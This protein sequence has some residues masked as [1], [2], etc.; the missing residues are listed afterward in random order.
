MKLKVLNEE[1]VEYMQKIKFKFDPDN[2]G[3]R[4]P[5]N[6][7]T[8][9][10]KVQMKLQFSNGHCFN[11]NKFVTQVNRPTFISEE[12]KVIYDK[13]FEYLADLI[14]SGENLN[15][16]SCDTPLIYSQYYIEALVS[17][18]QSCG[19]VVAGIVLPF[20]VNPRNQAPV[21][22]PSFTE[23]WNPTTQSIVS[24]LVDANRSLNTTSM[25]IEPSQ[26]H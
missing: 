3:C 21:L 16:S 10:V 13:D 26:M 25:S 2:T 5:I 23:D 15:I 11:V 8:A 7:V 9:N 12:T 24:L 6:H 14:I 22:K 18:S 4:I 17:Y 1:H 19:T 20:Y